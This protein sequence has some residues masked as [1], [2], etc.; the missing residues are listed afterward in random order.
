MKDY[1]KIVTT[2]KLIISVIY[3][4]MKDFFPNVYSTILAHILFCRPQWFASTTDARS[5]TR[6]TSDGRVGPDKI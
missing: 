2:I 6:T 5:I 4:N 3:Q 1:Y